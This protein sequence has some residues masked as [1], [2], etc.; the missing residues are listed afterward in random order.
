MKSKIRDLGKYTLLN[1]WENIGRDHIRD[2]AFSW[3]KLTELH[4][5]S[6]TPDRSLFV[7]I[8]F[9]C[10]VP[11]NSRFPISW[12]WFMM[13]DDRI[14]HQK[15]PDIMSSMHNDQDDR[16][17]ISKMSEWLLNRGDLMILRLPGWQN[18]IEGIR[19]TKSIPPTQ[20][21][22]WCNRKNGY[23]WVDYDMPLWVFNCASW[24]QMI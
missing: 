3:S 4:L 1:N 20:S 14:H 10:I 22:I 24:I 12:P 11:V 15:G 7:S 23:M 5:S 16:S 8:A 21:L 17:C 9:S 13:L 2:V 18:R 6:I 19:L